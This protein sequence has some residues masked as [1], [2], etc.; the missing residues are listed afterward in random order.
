MPN[1]EEPNWEEFDAI[2]VASCQVEL[3]GEDKFWERVEKIGPKRETI[4]TMY[5]HYKINFGTGVTALHDFFTIKDCLY[6]AEK[7]CKKHKLV[8]Y[9]YIIQ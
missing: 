7:I 5:G 9:N 1:G 8:I 4:Y 6:R 2:E 3:V